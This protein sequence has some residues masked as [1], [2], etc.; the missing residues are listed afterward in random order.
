MQ[1]KEA[2][3]VLQEYLRPAT[4]PVA[5]KM[6]AQESLPEKVRRPVDFLGHPVAVCQGISMARNMGWAIG[7]LREDHA[8]APSFIVLGLAEEPAEV[9]LSEVVYPL[10][11]ETPEACARTHEHM[12]TLPAGKIKSIIVSP[13]ERADFDPD[14]ILFYGNPAQIA[15]L[16]HSALY[17][18][19]GAITSAFIGRNSCAAELVAPL[20]TGQCQVIVPGSGERIF[21]LTQD[22]EM[23]FAIPRG[24]LEDVL[25]GLKTT[26]QLGAMRYPTPYQGLRARPQ[27]PKKYHQLEDAFNIAKNR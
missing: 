25:F 22:H 24:R 23:C 7:F 18:Q 19:G 27:Y 1:T 16:I 2:A 4:F 10:Y 20:L 21:A 11:G 6:S 3:A 26:H 12:H 9:K 5:V 13:L 15:R 14:I 17:R 8:C